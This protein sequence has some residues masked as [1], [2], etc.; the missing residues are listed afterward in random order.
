MESL[1]NQNWVKVFVHDSRR[2]TARLRD[3]FCGEAEWIE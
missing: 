2:S 3:R 1:A